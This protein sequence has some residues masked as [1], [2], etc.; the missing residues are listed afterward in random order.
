ML[1]NNPEIG[2]LFNDD[3][4]LPL[5]KTTKAWASFLANIPPVGINIEKESENNFTD[6]YYLKKMAEALNKGQK[7][8]QDII[9]YLNK[10][11][12]EQVSTDEDAEDKYFFIQDMEKMDYIGIA[13]MC[14]EITDEH[15]YR[16]AN[17]NMSKGKLYVVGDPNFPDLC[18]KYQ[19][20]FYDS[21]NYILKTPTL[22]LQG[23]IDPQTTLESAKY[24]YSNNQS[25]IKKFI[26]I[27]NAGHEPKKAELKSCFSELMQTIDKATDT[28]FDFSRILDKNGHCL[29]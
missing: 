18:K 5:G 29:R 17:F 21:K 1:K 12:K 23:S 9:S 14:K 22:Y 13:I 16:Y 2:R 3:Y 8:H 27:S 11:V 6:W 15:I 7:P 24:H 28:S 20:N 19:R 25:A 26:E 10:E 4:N